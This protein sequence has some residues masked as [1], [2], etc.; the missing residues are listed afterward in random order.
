M[1]TM[2]SGNGQW[3]LEKFDRQISVSHNNHKSHNLFFHIQL[4]P[5]CSASEN[6]YSVT[7]WI[8]RAVGT[9][10]PVDPHQ[11]VSTYPCSVVSGVFKNN[12][13]DDADEG[14]CN[15]ILAVA[16]RTWGTAENDILANSEKHGLIVTSEH[17]RDPNDKLLLD[18][19]M[20]AGHIS[21]NNWDQQVP[22]CVQAIGISGVSWQ[23]AREMWAEIVSEERAFMI[24]RGLGYMTHPM[25]M[26]DKDKDLYTS[27]REMSFNFGWNMHLKFA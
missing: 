25:F 16:H 19:K 6:L 4:K 5:E 10:F 18:P 22:L 3:S 15:E 8:T 1:R 23:Y 14:V 9:A 13:T 27:V 17:L 11:S 20:L 21:P 7:E 26:Y 24:G 12:C 2:A